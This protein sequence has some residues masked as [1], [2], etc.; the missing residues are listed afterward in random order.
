[1]PMP[2]ALT[3]KERWSAHE[4]V[5]QQTLSPLPP[6][7]PR[8][9]STHR[10]GRRAALGRGAEPGTCNAVLDQPFCR[11]TDRGEP[12][13][14]PQAPHEPSPS[15]PEP[16]HR[17]RQP[18]LRPKHYSWPPSTREPGWQ[19]CC[20]ADAG[21]IQPLLAEVSERNLG[22]RLAGSAFSCHRDGA[23]VSHPPPFMSGDVPMCR[24]RQAGK[25]AAQGSS[26]PGAL[27]PTG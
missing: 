22:D 19:S 23:P 6:A 2:I 9:P 13:Q 24:R 17:H 7:R 10:S 18:S 11:P 16:S 26:P 21:I 4:Q 20:R 15:K 5:S 27:S 3:S 12:S 1:M 14:S 25:P 8:R